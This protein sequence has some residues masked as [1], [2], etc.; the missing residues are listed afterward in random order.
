RGNLALDVLDRGLK[1]VEGLFRGG[2]DLLVADILLDAM[3]YR[4]HL[5]DVAYDADL[6]RLRCALA[7]DRQ[8]DSGVDGAAHLVDGVAE[9]HTADFRAVDLRDEVACQHARTF[10]RG[11]RD[12][13]DHLDQF[14][15]HRDFDA[16][17][18]KLSARLHAHVLRGF[19][20]EI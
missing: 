9:R 6:D 18:A 12:R 19:R 1:V 4:S 5:D 14:A 16:E 15:F 3:A 20:I 7:Q 17:S 8:F 2:V 10:S 13:R 11:A